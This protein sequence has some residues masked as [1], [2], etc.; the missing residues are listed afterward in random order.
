[1]PTYLRPPVVSSTASFHVSPTRSGFAFL[2]LQVLLALL[3]SLALQSAW[4]QTAEAPAPVQPATAETAGQVPG[5]TAP[6]STLAPASTPVA[7]PAEPAGLLDASA[8]LSG[9]VSM[10]GKRFYVSEYRLLVEVGGQVTANTRAAYFGGTNHGATRMS[11]KYDASSMDFVALQQLADRAYA[12]FLARLEAAGAKPEPAEAIIKEYGVIYE[13]NQPGSTAAAPVYDD[14]DLGY[15]KRK[16][17]VL[18][19]T[20]TLLNSR[21]FAG[22]GAGNLSGRMSYSKSNA[23]AISVAM[24]V[25]IAAQ[26]SSGGGSSLFKRGSSANASAAME[27]AG[28]ARA[29][30]LQSHAHSQSYLFKAPLAV[31]GDFATLKEVGGYDSQKDAAVGAIQALGRLFG[32]A[33]NNSKRVDMAVEVNMPAMTQMA[34]RGL[35]SM[36]Q[37]MANGMKP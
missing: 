19:P 5:A 1:M 16:Y 30:A 22:L 17:L 32:Q 27:I 9:S 7:S 33:A 8:N 36:H 18:A 4:S 10:K 35:A 15:G 31:P 29:A 3:A 37:A 25:H 23:E 24:A 2:G 26:E 21:G 12:D 34:L 6:A 13:A 20:G 11:V 14:L 28:A